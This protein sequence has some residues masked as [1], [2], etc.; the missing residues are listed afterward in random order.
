M[1]SLILAFYAAERRG[2][3]PQG[4][5]DPEYLLGKALRTFCSLLRPYCYAEKRHG[6]CQQLNEQAPGFQKELFRKT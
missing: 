4:L 1:Y 5:K 3:H 2:I 6:V